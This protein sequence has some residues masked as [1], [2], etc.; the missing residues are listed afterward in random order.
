M[1]GL[2]MYIEITSS[3]QAIG[4]SRTRKYEKNEIEWVINKIIDEFP[5]TCI[6]K[7]DGTESTYE[8]DSLYKDAIRALTVRTTLPVDYIDNIASLTLKSAKA[9]LPSDFAYMLEFAGSYTCSPFVP[10][11]VVSKTYQTIVVPLPANSAGTAGNYFANL[12]VSVNGVVIYSRATGY[13]AKDSYQLIRELEDNTPLK[14]GGKTGNQLA[15]T[16]AKAGADPV[17]TITYD[18][19]LQS[20]STVA[21]SFATFETVQLTGDQVVPI[22]NVRDSSYYDLLTT[23]YY[24]PKTSELLGTLD[25]TFIYLDT[26]GN[27]IVNGVLLSYIR[28]PRRISLSLNTSSDIAPEF[29]N[30]ICSRAVNYIR[31]RIG[32]PKFQTGLIEAKQ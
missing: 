21:S 5:K 13:Q 20:T 31:E 2:D 18:G 17:F 11:A 12:S 16:I 23:P 14:V 15:M 1:T 9:I 3:L 30:E 10:S 29:H 24:Q 6:R 4:A 27:I 28:K 7:K 8:I 26:P 22:K 25:S 19:I 32:D